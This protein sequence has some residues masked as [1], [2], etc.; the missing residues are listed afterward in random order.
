MNLRAKSDSEKFFSS[1]I[2]GACRKSNHLINESKAE[3][4]SKEESK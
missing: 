4:T 2:Q 3:I 1:L